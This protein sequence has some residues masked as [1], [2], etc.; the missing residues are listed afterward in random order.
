MKNNFHNIII[1]YAC[2]VSRCTIVYSCIQDVSF[3]LEGVDGLETTFTF[4]LTYLY[5]MPGCGIE[6][7]SINIPLSSCDDEICT[8]T[9]S[10]NENTIVHCFDDSELSKVFVTALASNILGSSLSSDAIQIGMCTAV[11][12]K[13]IS[14]E[15]VHIQHRNN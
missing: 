12:L 10:M 6:S 1:I 8:L 15:C 7:I 3:T 4:N 14:Y 5:S 11:K 2:F 13:L 9:L